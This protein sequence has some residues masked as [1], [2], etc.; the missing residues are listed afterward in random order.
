[1]AD[2]TA[3]RYVGNVNDWDTTQTVWVARGDDGN[4]TKE[5]VLGGDPVELTEE[6]RERASATARLRKAT[7]D[8]VE[9][10]VDTSGDP[11]TKARAESAAT[12]ASTDSPGGVSVDPSSDPSSDPNDSATSSSGRRSGR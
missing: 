3:Y 1:M 8:Q 6:E 2:T 7:D 10:A 11:E 4:V 9:K 5:L 12:S